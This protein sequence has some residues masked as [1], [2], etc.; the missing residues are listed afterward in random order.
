MAWK[1]TKNPKIRDIIKLL[2]SHGSLTPTDLSKKLDLHSVVVAR[3]LKQLKDDK[4]VKIKR[5]QNQLFYS[6]DHK[7]WKKHV[8]ATIELAGNSFETK[9]N[10]NM[11]QKFQDDVKS[12]AQR[13]I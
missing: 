1:S 12:P 11:K 2:G 6:L 9:F 4:L 13:G 3:Y 7:Q 8:E 10:E 5:K